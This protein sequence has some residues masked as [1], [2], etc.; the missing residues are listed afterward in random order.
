M[1]IVTV[2]YFFIIA[3]F[4]GLTI[5]NGLKIKLELLIK[6]TGGFLIGIVLLTQIIFWQSHLISF[7]G[8]NIILTLILITL[9]CGFLWH[10]EQYLKILIKEVGKI[11]WREKI[12]LLLFFLAWGGLFFMIWRKMLVMEPSGLYS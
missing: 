12:G 1:D 5:L 6:L 4:L 11:K 3:L 2:G 8:Q 7:S 9:I 10:K